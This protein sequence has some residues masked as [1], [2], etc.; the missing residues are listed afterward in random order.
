LFVARH[1][2]SKRILETQDIRAVV[3]A[4]VE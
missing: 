4:V 1:G 2:Y 3:G